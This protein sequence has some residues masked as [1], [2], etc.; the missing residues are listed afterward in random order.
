LESGP[1][2]ARKAGRLQKKVGLMK[3]VS[4]PTSSSAITF[5]M[6]TDQ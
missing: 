2:R 4:G 3:Y 6:R 5:A 1:G